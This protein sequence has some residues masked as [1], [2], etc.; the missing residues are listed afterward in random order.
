MGQAVKNCTQCG[1]EKPLADFY[2]HKAMKDGHLSA[3]K[4]CTKA[5]VRRHRQENSD[6]VRAYDRERSK[7]PHRVAKRKEILRNQPPERTKARYL[8]SNAIRDGRLKKQPCTFC[9]SQD[10]IEAHHHDYARPL[11]VTWLCTPCHRKFH[12]LERMATYRHDEAA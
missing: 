8:V 12:G 9:G 3:C 11:D 4:D 10:G 7:Q 1:E 2:A 5:R 6:R